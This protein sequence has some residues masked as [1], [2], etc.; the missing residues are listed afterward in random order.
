[1]LALDD[2]HV[3]DNP[4]VHEAVAFLLD[5]LP[6]QVTLALTTRADPPLPLSRLRARGELLELRASDLRFTTA[7]AETFLNQVMG[8]A[9]EPTLVAALEVRTEGWA[10][11]LQLAALSARGH[12]TAGDP[13]SA[14]VEGFVEAFSGS[15]R[16]VLDYLVEEVLD[17]QPEPVRSFLLDTS[18]LE[19]LCGPLCDALTGRD[20]GQR[21][22]QRLE[23]DNLFLV[24]L[25]DHRQWY[26]Y[27]HLF[28]DALRV[29]LLAEQPDRVQGLH[30]AASEWHAEYGTLTDAIGH[31]VAAGDAE[32]AA[33]LI[34][35]AL[36]EAR[37]RRHDRVIRDWL[38]AIPDEVVRRRPVLSTQ[39]AW[40]RLSEGDLEG[41]EVSLHHAEQ[42]LEAMSPDG[43]GS[44]SE[45]DQRRTLSAWIAI[46][47][48]SA[49]QA[50]GDTDA[51]AEHARR[52]LELAGPE[53][54]FARG[55]AAGFLGLAAWADGDLE[56]AVDTF[57]QAVASLHSAGNVTDELG[58]T[59]VLAEMWQA[60]GHPARARRLYEQALETAG[61]H[62]EL[63]LST[64]GDL[65]AGLAD[66]LR[67]QAELNAAE[68]H[69][70]A[71]QKLGETAS[72]PENQHRW[73]LARA[74]LLRTQG[75]LEGAL[76]ELQQAS[77]LYL[78]GFFPDV[79]P[80]P[81]VITRLKI[82]LGR[83]EE[84]WGWARE[85]QVAATD[86]LTY[87][88]EFNHLTLARLLIAQQRA[89]GDSGS[90]EDAVAL[91]DRLR[92]AAQAGG[93]GASVV[94]THLLLALAH[95]ARGQRAEALAQLDR[96]LTRAV[97]A[98]YVRLF[99]DEGAPMEDLL[100]AAQRRP[101]TGELA[102]AVLEAGA[103]PAPIAAP[104]ADAAPPPEGLSERELDVLRLLAS[105][106]TGPDIAGRLFMSVNTFRTHT[107][108]IFTKLEVNT[109]RAAVARADELNL[110]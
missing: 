76:S 96:A 108:H 109:R 25:D 39:Q 18:L 34:E 37:R 103:V 11:G 44:A 81:A 35:R 53:D 68:W 102:R 62:P 29:R 12:T 51:T 4:A 56:V 85:H 23:R 38:Q 88:A 72:L 30:R 90:L 101:G 59:V 74:G 22:L 67:E 32:A 82:T 98:G 100:H 27:H 93:R 3:I 105:D 110:L 57:T 50:R 92:S 15:H 46:Y 16:F 7:E 94:D 75:D 55:G 21:M 47:R 41:V 42:E 45:D 64:T 61:T 13:G 78:P 5:H 107:R 20:D 71:S 83:L 65:H 91:L 80:I 104:R 60:R 14:G 106:L 58:S 40:L 63:P 97:P 28:A 8:L 79:R 19:Q 95:D 54:H 36:P 69:L 33:D 43:Q 48:A 87:L 99:L 24:P 70:D 66:V 26:R 77:S 86:D 10:A 9:L 52:A 31:A 84:A 6:P 73:H 17:T 2:Y 1:V 89:H 49:A